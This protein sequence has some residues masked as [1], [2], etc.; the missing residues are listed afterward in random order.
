MLL[1]ILIEELE[2]FRDHLHQIIRQRGNITHSDVI[3]CS[4]RLDTV[5]L[6]I[7]LLQN[8]LNFE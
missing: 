7:Q 6:Q 4:Q 3:I 1:E 8:N 2:V 5:I